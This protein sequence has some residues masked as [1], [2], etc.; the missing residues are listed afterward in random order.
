MAFYRRYRPT[1]FAQV[2]GQEKVVGILKSQARHDAFHHAYLFYGHS[3]T[4]KTS[5]ARLLAMALN[6]HNRDGGEPCGECPS[7]RAIMEGNHWDVHEVDGA[8]FGKIEEVR[9]LISRAYLSP[10]GNKKVYIIDEAHRL[11]E[12]SWDCLLKLLEEPPPHLVI[13]LCSTQADKIPLTVKS[14]TQLFPFSPI[15]PQY[16]REKLEYIAGKEGITIE[17]RHIEFICEMAGGN[18]RQAETVLEQVI[19]LERG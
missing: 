7:C 10:L 1:K 14:R 2:L 3:G 15:S 4:G 11:S 5:C 12:A 16:I 6:C 9:E 18:L 19:C 13:M 17:A 8:R